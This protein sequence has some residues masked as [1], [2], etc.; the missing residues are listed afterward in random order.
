M[1]V[2]WVTGARGFIGRYLSFYLNKNGDKV[3]GLGHGAWPD[4]SAQQNGL[5]LWINGEI[6][7]GNLRILLEQSGPPDTIYHLAGGSSV[8]A[9]LQTPTEDFKRTVVS[10]ANLLDWV[11]GNVP[12][13]HLVLSSSAAIYGNSPLEKLTE[14]GNYTPYSP[15]GFHKRNAE[16]LCESYAHNFG[17]KIAIVRLFSIYGPGLRKQLIW[18]LCTRLKNQ[19]QNLNLHGTGKELRDWLYIDD[20]VQY[21]VRASQFASCAPFIIN[22][23][24]GKATCVR[25]IAEYV[26]SAWGQ[27]PNIV[28]SGNQHIGNPFSLVG[29][30]STTFEIHLSMTISQ[31]IANY[32]HWFQRLENY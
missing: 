8:G 28:F 26:C 6:D 2:T 14:Q 3:F 31:G 4:T 29:Q 19:P 17:L 10:T 18:D 15:Y 9:S 20:A 12:K 27:R 13:T 32:V 7:P 23:A 5:E 16:L 11:R 25:E 21:L 30:K 22:G 24:T 1:S